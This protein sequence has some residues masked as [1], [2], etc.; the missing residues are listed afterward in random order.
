[1]CES[2]LTKEIYNASLDLIRIVHD[3][4]A[5]RREFIS[6]L[7]LDRAIH[8]DVE[9]IFFTFKKL[10]DDKRFLNVIDVA[11]QK[12]VFLATQAPLFSSVSA[13][14]PVTQYNDQYDE[15]Y[16]EQLGSSVHNALS[17]ALMNIKNVYD[18]NSFAE[19]NSEKLYDNTEYLQTLAADYYY[20]WHKP[21][22]LMS[23]H[24]Q[25]ELHRLLEIHGLPE[26]V[27]PSI[28][29][30]KYGFHSVT[31]TIPELYC[32]ENGPIGPLRGNGKELAAA[33]GKG[34]DNRGLRT[35][36]KN[37][38]GFIR[39]ESTQKLEAYFQT[40]IQFEEARQRLEKLKTT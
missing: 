11:E 30:D 10:F 24:L 39:Q 25:Y 27:E 37:G 8:P 33:I 2:K 16:A 23:F 12:S 22:S 40:R 34:K 17:L 15:Y 9:H 21:S 26:G 32:D 7:V 6:I 19:L 35:W 31:T 14:Y 4:R 3:Y 5:V 28:L 13:T 20:S 36:N 38:A 18:P 1:M 29:G